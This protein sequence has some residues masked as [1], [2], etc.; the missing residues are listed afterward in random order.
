MPLLLLPTN[1]KEMI[2]HS[3]DP[4]YSNRISHKNL[5]LVPKVQDGRESC[6]L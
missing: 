6:I 3:Y 1:Q 2:K 4:E 5:I